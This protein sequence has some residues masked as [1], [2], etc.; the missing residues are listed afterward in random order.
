MV[1][2][3]RS[4][5]SL[6]SRLNRLPLAR[7]GLRQFSPLLRSVKFNHPELWSDDYDDLGEWAENLTYYESGVYFPVHL[8]DLIGDG[9][10]RVLHKLGNGAFAQVWLA[11]DLRP[12][13]HG[14]VSIKIVPA[15]ASEAR[16]LKYLRRCPQTHPGSKHVMQLL[17][18]FTIHAPMMSYEGLVLEVMSRNAFR[19]VQ[20]APHG[21]L[22]LRN[23]S[24][25]S[26]QVAMGLDYLHQCGIAHGDLHTGNVCFTTSGLNR[27]NEAQV[28]N[29]LGE[30][31]IRRIKRR[32]GRP[33]S[34]SMPRYTVRPQAFPQTGWELKIIDLG[35]EKRTAFFFNQ[36][37]ESIITPDILR[38]PEM[39]KACSSL[40]W[41]YRI[42]LWALGCLI[43]ELFVGKSPFESPRPDALAW[44][45]TGMIDELPQ[46][47]RS[48]FN[49]ERFIDPEGSDAD[50]LFRSQKI[51]KPKDVYR[52]LEESITADYD[53]I[54]G[55]LTH[56]EL[57]SLAGLLREILVMNPMERKAA[58][59][60]AE[61]RWLLDHMRGADSGLMPS[62]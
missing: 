41:D 5:F 42:D 8:G 56:D 3:R 4:A 14:Y 62:E 61:H 27:L 51:G 60:V 13:G 25:A 46:H 16:I 48:R 24:L 49:F 55:E 19:V 34:S 50:S 38:A 11:K 2:I 43:Y 59:E 54:G 36:K 7:R 45:M 57:R 26:R 9:R 39:L 33:L 18:H 44:E 35:Q 21:K 40:E 12:G 30:P 53:W 29:I 52:P 17:D 22:S 47:R 37:P 31:E 20:S 6:F 23:G 1:S 15:D 10:Y 28:L 32:D 58:G